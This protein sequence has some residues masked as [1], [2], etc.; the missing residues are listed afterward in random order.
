[1]AW[2]ALDAPVGTIPVDESDGQTSPGITVCR[3]SG[4][5]GP[6]GRC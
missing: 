5:P 4:V 3:T 2:L 1:M 6:F